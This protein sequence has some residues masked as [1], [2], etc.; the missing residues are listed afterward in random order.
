MHFAMQAPVDVQRPPAEFA[1]DGPA[2]PLAASSAPIEQRESANASPDV[3][4]VAFESEIAQITKA[5]PEPPAVESTTGDPPQAADWQRL[6]RE[7]A[8]DLSSRVAPAPSTTAEVHQHVSLRMLR[9]LAGDTEGALEPIPHVSAL[10]QDYWS[11][12]M[13]A[14]ATYLDHH[15]QPDDKRRAAA[16]VTHLD[17][18]VAHLRELGVLSLRNLAFCKNV[19]GYGAIEPFEQDRFSPGEEVSLYVEIENYHSRST[20]AGFCTLLGSSYELVDERGKRVSGGEFPDVE[21]CCRTRRRDFHIQYGL[22]LP[23]TLAPGNYRLELVVKDRQSDKIGSAAV[24]F[25]V[26]PAPPR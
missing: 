11:R 23:S 12:Q 17:E 9:L 5:L 10:E 3:V 26:R 16:S 18:A 15:S 4:P 25:E 19:Y 21:D 8:S 24:G 2:Y 13:F 22:A 1:S 7:A 14:L 20:E 6:V